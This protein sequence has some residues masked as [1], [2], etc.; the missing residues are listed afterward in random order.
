MHIS[1]SS[2]SPDCIYPDILDGSQLVQGDQFK[3]LRL[4]RQIY[5][6]LHPPPL[7]KSLRTHKTHTSTYISHLFAY[8]SLNAVPSEHLTTPCITR[9]FIGIKSD[10]EHLFRGI[11]CNEYSK[12][13]KTITCLIFI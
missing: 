10:L 6:F 9:G 5:K 4:K 11:I 12:A 1:L 2:D 3:R 7:Q 8:L 13:F